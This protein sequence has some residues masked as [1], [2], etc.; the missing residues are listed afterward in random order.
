MILALDQGTSSS[1]ALVF[2]S[3]GQALSCVQQSFQQIYP[4][5]GWVEHD[6]Q[7]I[8]QSQLQVA[9]QALQQA[10]IS[11]NAITGIGITNQRETTVLWDR[12]TG[13]ALYNAIVWQDRRTADY[14]AK[15]CQADWAEEV[16]S[17]TGL[18]LDAYFSATKLHW[19]LKNIPGAAERAAAGTLCF[20]TIDT[21]LLWH[22]TEGKVHAT[23]Y[24]N[25]ARTLLFNIH[26]LK[27]DKE[28]LKLFEIPEAVLPEVHPSSHIFGYSAKHWLGKSLPI[29]GIAGDQQAAL[30]GQ[31]CSQPGMAKNTYG[32]GC[33]MLMNTGEQA[34][35]SKHGLL[36]TLACGTG[37]RPPYALEGSV[38]IA[39]AAVQ[40]LRDEL[41]LLDQSADSAY[42]ASKVTDTQGVYV[43]PAF[44]GLGAPY[45]NMEARGA[46]LGLTRGSNKNHLIRAT[47][48]S[49]A[50]QTRDVLQAMEQDAGLELSCLRVDGGAA[51]NNFLMQ[52]QA[53]IL[54][55]EVERPAN[56]E[57]TALGTAYLAGLAVGLWEEGELQEKWQLG[58][59][60]RPQMSEQQRETLYK[61]WLKAVAQING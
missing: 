27:W 14:C 17:R 10:Q 42:F 47:L 44:A 39:G 30:F 55:C 37:Q 60:F 53:D 32:T 38:F 35:I 25:A 9:R 45:W 20:G 1:R 40:W 15:L 11:A 31:G 46:I 18:V 43:V 41:G 12:N 16:R 56:I 24:S 57:S 54:G 52:F 4:K 13:Q 5:A 7:E 8:L 51:A 23:D 33:F 6:P 34:V 22:L 26:D 50:Y 58:R 59:Q 61:G 29:A 48:E 2:D 21:W 3:A 36:T 19:L 28:L 49:L